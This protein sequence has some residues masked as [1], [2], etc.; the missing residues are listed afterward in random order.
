[1]LNNSLPYIIT[2]QYS[3]SPWTLIILWN[4]IPLKHFH[5]KSLRDLKWKQQRAALKKKCLKLQ[6]QLNSLIV[7]HK[8]ES[9]VKEAVMPA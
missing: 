5:F 9:V 3:S 1:M 4:K 7:S 2:F 8:L 6:I